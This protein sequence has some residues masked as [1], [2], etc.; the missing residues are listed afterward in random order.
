MV[1]YESIV[2]KLG[3]DPIYAPPE[4]DSA[5]LY[6]DDSK[7]SRYHV[8]SEEEAEFLLDKMLKAKKEGILPLTPKK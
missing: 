7:P 5:D 2:K 4:Y 1:T 3:F 6:E 8:L